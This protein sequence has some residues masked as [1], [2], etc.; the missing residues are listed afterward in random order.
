MAATVSSFHGLLMSVQRTT[1]NGLF[2][3]FNYAW[4]H[5][6]NEN[7]QGGGGPNPVQNVN[8]RA[9]DWGNS[10][11]DQRHSLHGSINYRLPFGRSRR[12]GGWS[13]SAINSFRTG[14]PLT[15]STSRKA[16]DVPD[17]N[18]N[19][20]RPNV[21][22]GVSLIPADGQTI[23]HWANIAAFATP[24]KGCGGMP[25]G[26]SCRVPVCSRSTRRW[27]KTRRSPSGWAWF[28]VPMSLTCSIIPN[29]AARIWT[30]RRRPPSGGLRV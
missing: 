9:C 19:M 12:W 17:G 10:A 23:D 15:V 3:N 7:S 28:S 26:T 20:Q 16:G 5:A 30:S 1:R 4:S 6:Q 8:C 21:V 14:L 24:A 18:T 11:S 22:P 2:L 25:D 13:I 27:R 29:S